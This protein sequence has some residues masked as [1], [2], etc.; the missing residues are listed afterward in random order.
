MRNRQ[1][2][3]RENSK[4]NSTQMAQENQPAEEGKPYQGKQSNPGSLLQLQRRYGNQYVQRLLAGGEEAE[5]AVDREEGGLARWPLGSNAGA[6]ETEE[7]ETLE[8]SEQ[9]YKEK[10]RISYNLVKR[11]KRA[12]VSNFEAM[13]QDEKGLKAI[14]VAGRVAK[15]L[16]EAFVAEESWAGIYLG[17]KYQPIL[18]AQILAEGDLYE[19]LALLVAMEPYHARAI[20]NYLD[21]EPA[22]GFQYEMTMGSGGGGEGAEAV[23]ALM[24]ITC[25]EGEQKLW[26]QK[27][28]FV[29][30]GGGAS[31]LPFTVSGG[32]ASFDSLVYWGPDD[33]VG[34]MRF[35][36][37]SIGFGLGY[38]LGMGTISGDGSK[39][40]LTIDMSGFNVMTPNVAAGQYEGYLTKVGKSFAVR[41]PTSARPAA[42]KISVIQQVDE[43]AMVRFEENAASFTAFESESFMGVLVPVLQRGDFK[44]TISGSSSYGSDHNRGLLSA[45]IQTVRQEIERLGK[46]AGALGNEGLPS[47]KVE[48]SQYVA[49]G[50]PEQ[51]GEDPVID[52]AIQ[53]GLTGTMA[54]D[55]NYNYRLTSTQRALMGER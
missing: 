51:Q 49:E 30:G 8:V 17:W 45:R 15:V 9:G 33:L 42:P 44:L 54:T 32:Q 52:R 27:Y 50:E 22:T 2:R 29:G 1:R 28:A 7:E 41:E 37:Y 5:G 6:E 21:I 40:S 3:T 36:G 43:G 23:A 31:V 25:K 34:H 4:S 26:E 55:P 24:V 47:D 39:G 38:G 12:V 20:K 46:E 19:K 14:D 11:I 18:K 16:K 13:V 53:V 48:V 35:G 10:S